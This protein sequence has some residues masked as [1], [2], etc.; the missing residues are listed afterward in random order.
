MRLIVLLAALFSG[1]AEAVTV[2]VANGPPRIILRVGGA[3]GGI[4][5]VT[6]TLTAA[7]VGN[8]TPVNAAPAILVRATA[9][10]LAATAGTRIATLTADSSTALSNGADTIPF[11]TISWT[12]AGDLDIPAG[13]FT[14][15]AG[16]V[17]TSFV[18]SN[19]VS[20][21]HTFSYDNA[22]VF[23]AG[24]YNGRVIYT[25]SMP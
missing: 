4:N 19:Q 22:Q 20:A 1:S 3:G 9:R 6:F 11:T 16:Q 7:N 12:A 21:N 13:T 23:P 25:L 8:G 17:L 10:E 2:A 24:T 15:A 18:T 14:G 5:L